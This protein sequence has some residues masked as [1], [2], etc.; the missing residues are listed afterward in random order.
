MAQGPLGG[1]VTR[2]VL[3]RM[4]KERGP[5]MNDPTRALEWLKTLD[6]GE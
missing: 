6:E 3:E 1:L 2:G 4:L 5:Q